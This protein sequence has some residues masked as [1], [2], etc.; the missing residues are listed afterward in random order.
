RVR[1]AGDEIRRARKHRR[2][3]RQRGLLLEA[4]RH[5]LWRRRRRDE[6]RPE[7]GRGERRRAA[8][9]GQHRH[10]ERNRQRPGHRD[11]HQVDRA[12]LLIRVL[13]GGRGLRGGEGGGLLLDFLVAQ[14]LGERRAVGQLARAGRNTR[15]GE[16]QRIGRRG[17]GGGRRLGGR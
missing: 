11:R 14:V 12:R 9:H 15:V 3:D 1:R 8:R 10:G 17:G 5:E 6:R 2:R 16:R 13:G 4:G 7:A